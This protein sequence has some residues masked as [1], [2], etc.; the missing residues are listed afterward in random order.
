M[1]IKKLGAILVSVLT[2]GV[3]GACAH[4][5]KDESA[6]Q[7]AGI[8]RVEISTIPFDDSLL[9]RSATYT[10]SG[11]VLV[12]YADRESEDPRYVRLAVMDDDGTNMQPFF[13]GEIPH[14]DKDNGIRFMTFPDNQRIFLGDFILECAPSIDICTD[15]A[16]YPVQY[17]EEVAEGD[18]ISHRWSEIITAPDNRHVAWTTLLSNYSAIVFVGELHK[19]EERYR[20]VNTRIVSTLDPFEQDP[21]HADGVLPQPI[22]GG[23]V[24]QFVHGGEAISL[25]GALR[26]DIPDTVVHHL[27]SG[28]LEAI[29]DTPGYTETTIFSPDEQLG[30]TM[31]TRFSEHTDPAILGLVPRP[32]PA[33]LNMGLSMHAYTYSVVGV[34]RARS[35]NVG[36]ALIDISGSK[37]QEDYLGVNLNTEDEWVYRSP[38]SW[39][40]SSKKAMWI[41]GLRG[42]NQ[43]R[44]QRVYL[45][46]YHSPGAV[47][48]K[49]VPDDIPGSSSD[50]SV[51]REYA[52]TSHDIDVTVYGRDSGHIEYTRSSD[53]VV[54]K[55]YV[56]FSDDGQNT[57]SGRERMESNPQGRS[58]YIADLTLSGP[59][60]GVMDLKVTFG[61]LQASLPVEILFA[62]DAS[63]EPLTR[64]YAEYGGKRLEVEDL[65]P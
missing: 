20:I 46:D 61:P 42:E 43:R 60:A 28:E 32:Y 52:A 57:Y 62:E 2:A 49:V 26:R 11:K 40:P 45:P 64:G 41:E 6:T 39:H 4:Q 16:L 35:G 12:S 63:G 17:P 54:E 5:A 22:R 56:N 31:T 55:T 15:S 7:H 13:A 34:R 65:L 37:E 30:I 18:Y 33:S 53:G 19:S 3:M 48:A 58:T 1:I 50:L 51:V 27:S 10:P 47:M 25:V 8:G 38:M 29:T 44:I 24:K 23:E 21:A 59:E 9:V 14:R 36:P